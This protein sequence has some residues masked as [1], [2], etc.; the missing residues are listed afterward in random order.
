MH[1]DCDVLGL[2][3]VLVDHQVVVP[4]Y[5]DADM[6]TEVVS[7]RNQI[8]GPVPTALVLLSRW[9]HGCR[10]I[11]KWAADAAGDAIRA[12]L[13][14]ERVDTSDCIA[15]SDGSTGFAHVW[16][17]QRTGTRTLAA[18]RGDF[19]PIQPHE[20][21]S[22]LPS[23][24][25]LH[26]DGWAGEA[27]VS[28]AKA[29]RSQGGLVFLD[30]GSPKPQMQR[31]LPHVDVVSCPAR[32][33]SLFP[34]KRDHVSQD[35]AMRELLQM[36]PRCAIVTHGDQGASGYEDQHRYDQSAF[37]VSARDTTGAGDVFCGALVY[38]LLHDWPLPKNLKFASATAA[39]KCEQM[40][41]RDALPSFSGV[42]EFLKQ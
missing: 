3:T 5:P 21:P 22:P 37:Q 28:A 33:L 42:L 14:H 38:G 1:T 34:W 6:K 16:I 27:A 31:L 36:G 20:L 13:A 9:G 40:G 12:D 18:W 7:Y 4:Q 32:F 10:F 25:V 2:G 17:D 19:P 29:V 26:L 41:N 15:V 30:T 8:G 11:G 35:E 39:L 24:R 23:C